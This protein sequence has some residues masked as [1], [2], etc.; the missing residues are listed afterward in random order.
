MESDGC[1]HGRT[2]LVVKSLSR[3]KRSEFTKGQ[4]FLQIS[5]IPI[6]GAL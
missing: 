3:L 4:N 6:V 2:T 5:L 1:T